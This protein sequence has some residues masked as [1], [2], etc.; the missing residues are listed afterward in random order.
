VIV[1]RYPLSNPVILCHSSTG[2]KT[3]YDL[4]T[5]PPSPPSDQSVSWPR[6]VGRVNTSLYC[7]RIQPLS[8]FILF[9]Y[10]KQNV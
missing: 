5:S 9:R 7:S 4:A 6:L 1:V 2:K 10:R 8:D 3:C